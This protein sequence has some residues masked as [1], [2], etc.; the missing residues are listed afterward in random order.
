MEAWREQSSE[1]PMEPNW[2]LKMEPKTDPMMGPMSML[3][4]KPSTKI[5][6]T[7]KVSKWN[8]YKTMTGFVNQAK[9]ESRKTKQD[10]PDL[11]EREVSQDLSM[12][13]LELISY[14]T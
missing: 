1:Q 13:L 5:S 9:K 8:V 6:S 11:I 10:L 3:K 2:K 7:K 14:I 12:W 4:K